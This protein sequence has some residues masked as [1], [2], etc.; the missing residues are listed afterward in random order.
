MN[1]YYAVKGEK[2]RI[3]TSWEECQAYISANKGNGYTHKSFSSYDEA[4]CFISGVDYYDELISNDFNNGFVV[5][6][7]DGSYEENLNKYAYGVVALSKDKEEHFYGVGDEKEFLPSRNIA[8]EVLGVLQAVKW[9]ILNGYRKLKI[10]HD[11]SGLSFWANREWNAESPIASFYKQEFDKLNHG[12][13]V[14]FQKVK[15]HSNDKYNEKVDELAKKALFS[16]ESKTVH[17]QFFFVSGQDGYK[18]ITE[19]V[20]KNAKPVAIEENGGTKLTI[21][22]ASIFVFP[23]DNCTVIC[24]QNKKLFNLAILGGASYEGKNGYQR[25]IKRVLETDEYGIALSKKLIKLDDDDS[26]LIF[27]LEELHDFIKNKLGINDKISKCFEKSDDGFVCKKNT[28]DK[29]LLEKAYG[30][31]YENRINFFN[32][33]NKNYKKTIKQIDEILG[34]EN[35]CGN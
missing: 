11:Y 21:N 9:A 1:K 23:R 17:G 18:Y 22:G 13:E 8:G 14:V 31:F 24:G 25:I 15:G 12:I 19:Y 20:Y 6:Y 2:S 16:N 34:E 32:E 35:D 5:A 26:S 27:A 4:E 28:N 7:T 33:E 29:K 3:F 10:Y 30:I